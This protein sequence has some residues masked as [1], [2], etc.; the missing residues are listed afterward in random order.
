MKHLGVTLAA[1]VLVVLALASASPAATIQEVLTAQFN[2]TQYDFYASGYGTSGYY[3]NWTDV[4][5]GTHQFLTGGVTNGLTQAASYNP[6]Y[7]NFS[8]L[9]STNNVGNSS[10]SKSTATSYI[11]RNIYGL[12][13]NTGQAWSTDFSVLFY[14]PKFTGTDMTLEL[15]G[16]V[17]G[18]DNDMTKELTQAEVV[19]GTMVKYHIDASAGESIEVA[20]TSDGAESYAAGFFLDNMTLSGTATPEV[21]KSTSTGTDAATI[22]G[23]ELPEPATLLLLGW[24]RPAWR[25]NGAA[26]PDSTFLSSFTRRAA[27]PTAALPHCAP[28]SLVG[29]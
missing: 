12:G 10:N 6:S 26:R 23:A 25:P 16:S 2:P 11:N 21:V 14:N 27:T 1:S 17:N 29:I 19:A 24:A 7:L 18:A 22:E 3:L 20:V 4:D 15:A 5:P 13:V 28:V 8:T 9:S